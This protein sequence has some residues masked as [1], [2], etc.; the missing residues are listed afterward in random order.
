MNNEKFFKKCSKCGSIE[1]NENIIYEI[2]Y[3]KN[4]YGA[5]ND[6]YMNAKISFV[7][8]N[9]EHEIQIQ[10][11]EERKPQSCEKCETYHMKDYGAYKIKNVI[12]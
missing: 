2:V 11:L 9:V 1:F 4:L 3:Y 6:P 7:D 10:F 12:K 8:L 5:K